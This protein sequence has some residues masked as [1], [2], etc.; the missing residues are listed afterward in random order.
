MRLQSFSKGEYIYL[1]SQAI[2]SL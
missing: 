1:R 2:N